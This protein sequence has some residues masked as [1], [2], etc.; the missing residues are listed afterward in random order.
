[1]D[2]GQLL[3]LLGSYHRPGDIGE[4]Y[5]AQARLGYQKNIVAGRCIKEIS[6]GVAAIPY[7]VQVGGKEVEGENDLIKLLK[8]PNPRAT[9]RTMIRDLVIHRLISGNCYLRAIRVSTGRV[10]ELQVLRPDRVE[11]KTAPDCTPIAYDYTING[12]VQSFP[13][14]PQTGASE[15]LHI[16]EPNPLD[17]R[18][19]MSPIR[20]ASLGIS[21]HN[22]SAEWNL[23]LL[24]NSARPPGI[25]AMKPMGNAAVPPSPEVIKKLRDDFNEVFA[26]SKNAGKI[27]FLTFDMEW[28]A[29]G[30]SPAD[31]EWL[32]GKNSTA[33]EVAMA[34]GYPPFLLGLPEGSTFNN[35]RE[36]KLHFYQVTVVPL[37]EE[38]NESISHWLTLLGGK[39]GKD[40]QIIADL[41]AVDALALQRESILDQSRKDFEAGIISANEARAVRKYDEVEGGDDLLVPAGK[42]PL[43]FDPGDLDD[44]AFEAYLVGQG[45][46]AA[47]AQRIVKASANREGQTRGG[48][49]SDAGREGSPA[50]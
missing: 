34:L 47:A 35:V 13:I 46:S 43:G 21:Q 28:K 24:R 15:I 39:A 45:L 16:K 14:D 7:F 5:I 1:M 6:Q 38:I 2:L 48:L 22:E 33:R 25:V 11:I 31:M 32:N 50:S 8:R 42:L 29:L 19:G 27:P 44:Q 37:A 23:N 40:V 49:S 10:M 36:A 4:D 12:R 3:S 41:D 17:D 18:Y 20:Q 26:G 9:W 30:M